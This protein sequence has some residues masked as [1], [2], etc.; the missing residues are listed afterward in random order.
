MFFGFGPIGSLE[1]K[2]NAI[3]L[4]EQSA[5]L[6]NI[7][8]MLALGRI[9]DHGIGRTQPDFMQALHYYMIAGYD[10]N[11][12]NALYW[13][14][15]ACEKGMHPQIKGNQMTAAFQLYKQAAALESKEA[16]FKLGEF[17]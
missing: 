15:T 7:K 2:E 13:L 3:L 5:K 8:A 16:L 9:Y 10:A 12:R 17:Y 11:E 14:G 6:G 1:S 4:Y